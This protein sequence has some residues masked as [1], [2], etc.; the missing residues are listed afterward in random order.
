METRYEVPDRWKTP[1]RSHLRERFGE[2]RDF[3]I[4]SDLTSAITLQMP[5][6]F[7]AMFV[8]ALYLVDAAAGEVLV[9]TRGYGAQVFPLHGREI[10]SM[11]STDPMH[12]FWSPNRSG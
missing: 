5:N 1:L 4:E 6:G 10:M 9:C 2:E 12:R 3:I 7:P 8:D 11:P